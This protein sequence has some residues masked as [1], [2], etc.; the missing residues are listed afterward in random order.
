MEAGDKLQEER[1]CVYMCV[2]VNIYIYISQG[3]C[4]ERVCSFSATGH[5]QHYL[6]LCLC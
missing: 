6:T 5:G 4:G 2:T 1:K 3:L